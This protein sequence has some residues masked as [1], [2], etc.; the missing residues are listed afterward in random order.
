M[1]SMK[2]GK[3]FK[4][5]QNSDLGSVFFVLLFKGTKHKHNEKHSATR[6]QFCATRAQFEKVVH[7]A[8]IHQQDHL[9]FLTRP[10]FCEASSNLS[11]RQRFNSCFFLVQMDVQVHTI[12]IYTYYIYTH[13]MYHIYIYV[14]LQLE[15]YPK[16]GLALYRN[17]MGRRKLFPFFC[18]YPSSI[19]NIWTILVEAPLNYMKLYMKLNGSHK[20]TSI[21]NRDS[22]FLLCSWIYH[23]SINIKSLLN[24]HTISS[25]QMS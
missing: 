20:L 18:V 5:C 3:S 23:H 14:H 17:I 16:Y 21:W 22:F 13:H 15:L 4:F 7:F 2:Y 19:A 8:Q 9:L 24:H 1:K 11:K 6:A 25:H 10:L 12:Y